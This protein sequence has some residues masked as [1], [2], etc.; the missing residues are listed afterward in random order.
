MNISGIGL[1]VALLSAIYGFS[2]HA[3]T[4]VGPT[5]GSE[6]TKFLS[7][8]K[9]T[10]SFDRKVCS[11][12]LPALK[13]LIRKKNNQVSS[14]TPSSTAAPIS[15]TVWIRKISATTE[16]LSHE[17]FRDTHPTLFIFDAERSSGKGQHAVYELPLTE[18]DSGNPRM[19]RSFQLPVNSAFVGNREDILPEFVIAG[20]MQNHHVMSATY[21]D[22]VYYL[23]NI[24]INSRNPQEQGGSLATAAT[25]S[26]GSTPTKQYHAPPGILDLRGAG[27]FVAD[28][29]KVVLDHAD[30]GMRVNTVDLGCTDYADGRG[31]EE[32]FIY[33]FTDSDIELQPGLNNVHNAALNLECYKETG[34]VRLTMKNT[35]TVL[36]VSTETDAAGRGMPQ[37]SSVLF[38][39]SLLP[40]ENILSFFNSTCNSVVDQFRNDLSIDPANPSDPDHYMG[41]VFGSDCSDIKMV[42]GAFGLKD[43]DQAW[44]WIPV[45]HAEKESCWA[46]YEKS[47]RAGFAPVGVWSKAGF[48]VACTASPFATQ[49]P[50]TT[51]DADA[52]VGNKIS[53]SKLTGLEIIGICCL[54]GGSQFIAQIWFRLSDRIRQAWIRHTS[55]VL[56][57]TLG[58]GLPALQLV[59]KCVSGLKGYSVSPIRHS[60]L[61]DDFDSL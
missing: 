23:A 11:Q 50:Y 3:I 17:V 46:Q 27:I 10:S 7:C 26:P 16:R 30:N 21:N 38:S 55:Q 51:A 54:F 15:E 40:K 8:S 28:N 61:H 32:Y 34:Q 33:R 29:I 2:C 56:A 45:E 44:G 60:L 35:T 58:L 47:Y 52:L 22:S 49:I 41:G 31:A 5:V 4:T 39:I 48:N 57:A 36:S 37:G 24:K 6:Y 9:L 1:A 12:H 53:R 18:P 59:P 25:V 19:T 14:A 13:A 43:S 20:G 42:Q